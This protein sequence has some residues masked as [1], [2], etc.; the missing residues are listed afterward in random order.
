MSDQQQPEDPINPN[1]YTSHPSGIQCVEISKHLSGCL[2][3]AFQYVWR[4]GQ[5]DDPIQDLKK[6]IWF[7]DTEID[8]STSDK[9]TVTN[10]LAIEEP[11]NLVT[12][13]EHGLKK[14][15]LCY[16]ARANILNAPRFTLLCKAGHAINQLIK[17]YEAQK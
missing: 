11:L 15:A 8:I 3:Q 7:I 4:C 1:H 12:K 16:I 6:A 9:Q 5:K 10:I 14:D 17:D 13:Y 2:A